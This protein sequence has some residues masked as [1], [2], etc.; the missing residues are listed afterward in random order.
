MRRNSRILLLFGIIWFSG[1]YLYVRNSENTSGVYNAESNPRHGNRVSK[2]AH[3]K[4]YKKDHKEKIKPAEDHNI[5]ADKLEH[6]IQDI[7]HGLEDLKDSKNDE[8]AAIEDSI[9]HDL[10]DNEE[11]DY[12]DM[13]GLSEED[14]DDENNDV[15][16]KKES[17]AHA[18]PTGDSK[19]NKEI[20]EGM[21][22]V[23][24]E[25]DELQGPPTEKTMQDEDELDKGDNDEDYED[26]GKV[27]WWNFDDSAYLAAGALGADED[28]YEANKFNQAASDR[29]KSDRAVPDTRHKECS[30]QKYQVEQLPDTTVIITYHNEAHSTLLRTVISVLHRSPPNL[31]K[32]IIL[33]DDFSKNPNIGPPL[34][35]I[36][37]VKAIRNPKREGLIRSRVRGAAIAT[38][39]VLTFLDSHVEANEGWL[40]P[41]L[42]RIHESRTAVVS[43]IIDVIGMDDFHYVGASADL[44]GGFN[45]DLVFKWDYMS[46]QERRERR[47]APTSP[48]RTPMIAGGLFSIEKNWFHELGEYDMDMDVWGGE[49]LEIS[50]RVWQC[51]GTLEIIPCS[52][53]GHVFRKKHPYTFPGGSG[54]VFAKNTRRAAEVWMDEYK[55]FYFAA[56]PSAKM[57]K[58]GDISKRTEVRER[59][60]CKSF[61][62][63][64]ENVYPEL[65]IPNKDAIGWGA[66]SQT[67]N[68]LEECID[69]LGNTHGG[70][71]LGMYRCHGDGGNQEFTLTKEGKEFRHN[72]L[73]I[74][75]NAKEPVG[76]PVKFNTCHQMSHQRWEYFGSQI[77]P[78]GHTNLCLDSKNHLEKGL[79]LEM[80]N[81]SKTQVFSFEMRNIK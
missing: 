69:T 7:E 45:W 58:F 63:F 37:K 11:K 76:N 40:E 8:F 13:E 33:V 24:F 17:K 26:D 28:P 53:V 3:E 41:L 50:F 25:Q 68:G 60:Q 43:P 49:N 44:K 39:K 59:L 38:G 62:W 1:V 79:T 78:E 52:R 23:E 18:E 72:D 4:H 19:I 36:K 48:I 2:D 20:E 31:I 70:G 80:C 65:R 9:R 6:D 54:N 22:E 55:E 16:K 51:H 73:C 67:N 75:Y 35:K 30:K 47:R 66:V 12:A 57:V 74:G 14:D 77:K 21:E 64:L 5:D 15:D 56:V 32:E 61:S 29:I 81:H 42:G 34:T 71:T 10:A 46:E 27:D